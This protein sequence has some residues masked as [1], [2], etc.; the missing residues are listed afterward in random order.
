MERI[1]TMADYIGSKCIICGNSF[2]ENDD[3]VVCPE[4]GTPYHRDCYKQAGECVN[5]ELHEKGAS[6]TKEENADGIRCRRCGYN[7]D[8]DKLFCESCG[9]A[10]HETVEETEDRESKQGT[11]SGETNDGRVEFSPFGERTVYDKDSVIDGIKLEDYAGYVKS[12]PFTFLMSF[13]RFGKYGGKLSLNIGAFLFPEVYYLF[14]KMKV[15]GVISLIVCA[16]LTVP[17]MIAQFAVGY[18]GFKIAFSFDTTSGTF[19]MIADVSWYVLM[20]WKIVSGL[21][22]NYFYYRK[23]KSDITRIRKTSDGEEEV[24]ERIAAKGGV[25]WAYALVGYGFFTSLVI[26]TVFLFNRI[27]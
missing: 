10:L 4:C 8:T 11:Y 23:A 20:M 14:R 9:T 25:S 5:K 17:M 24:K 16:A 15:L 27:L 18:A 7:N 3:V 21:M 22:A 13:I 6:W 1:W 26:G 2:A 19:K 12:N